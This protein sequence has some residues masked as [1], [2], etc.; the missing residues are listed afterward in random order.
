MNAKG[1]VLAIFG[2]IVTLLGLLWLVQG[3]GIVQIGPILCVADC[4]PVT[5]P[6]TQ[7]AVI[8]AITLV[9]GIAIG[10]VGL[11]RIN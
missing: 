10:G 4:E 3:L 6:S 11:R 5:G 7:W 1:A 9:V 8:G 2:A